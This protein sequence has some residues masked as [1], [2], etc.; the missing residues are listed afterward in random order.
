MMPSG[1]APSRARGGGVD[2]F[3]GQAAGGSRVIAAHVDGPVDP[4]SAPRI[5]IAGVRGET[6]GLLPDSAFAAY[7]V[8]SRVG[9]VTSA[10]PGYTTLPSIVLNTA[11]VEAEADLGPSAKLRADFAVQWGEY[12]AKPIRNSGAAALA[13]DLGPAGGGWTS[14][15]F[16]AYGSG[17]R[18]DTP[19]FEGF[20]PLAQDARGRWDDAGL[21]S[22]RNTWLGGVRVAW[23]S[24]GGAEVGARFTPAVAPEPESPSGFL[25]RGFPGG[26]GGRIG[27][28][29]S[30]FAS[31]PLFEEE[32]SFLKFSY[33]RFNPGDYFASPADAA[34]QLGVELGFGF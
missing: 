26:T 29:L 24:E 17:D 20:I 34:S 9:A 8:Y 3:A 11:G 27:E 18:W 31:F 16:A 22:S 6:R 21:L 14:S 10:D 28:I 32:K 19:E 5:Q 2:V 23:A 15:L 12:G 4:D 13:L 33:T 30:L 1:S 7:Y 25:L